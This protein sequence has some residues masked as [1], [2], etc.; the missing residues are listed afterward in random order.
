MES[1]RP[2]SVPEEAGNAEA[3]IHGI[4]EEHQKGGQDADEGSGGRIVIFSFF[5]S[6]KIPPDIRH[7]QQFQTAALILIILICRR[8]RQSYLSIISIELF[9]IVI[10]IWYTYS[11]GGAYAGRNLF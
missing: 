4:A 11:K 6:D 10:N 9:E 7:V 1:Q 5:I 3:H 2:G 8:K